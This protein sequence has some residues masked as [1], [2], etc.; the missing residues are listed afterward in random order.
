MNAKKLLGKLLIVLISFSACSTANVTVCIL[1]AENQ[2]LECAYPNG[3]DET[4][5]LMRAHNYICMSPDDAERLMN[6]ASLKC[7]K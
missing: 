7:S 6:Y 2:K 4:I 5:E 1:D 3:K